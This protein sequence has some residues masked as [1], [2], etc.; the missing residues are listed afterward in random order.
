MVKEDLQ[1]ICKGRMHFK[2][3][4]AIYNNNFYEMT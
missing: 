2:E 4:F 1:P 3:R